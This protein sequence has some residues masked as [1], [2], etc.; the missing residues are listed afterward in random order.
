MRFFQERMNKVYISM[1]ESV[2]ATPSFYFSY[3]YDITH[4]LQRLHNTSP[5]YL[6]VSLVQEQKDFQRKGL[7]FDRYIHR[8]YLT[9][10]QFKNFTA[11]NIYAMNCYLQSSHRH[12][13]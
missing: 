9:Q 11:M 7:T 3:S 10:L 4:S 5:E 1:V 12:L 8:V 6:K 2:L 13:A